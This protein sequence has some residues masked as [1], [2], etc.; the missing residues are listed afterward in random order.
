MSSCQLQSHE[1]S[2]NPLHLKPA[3][4]Q[5]PFSLMAAVRR[6][7][8][9]LEQQRASALA[10]E[11]LNLANAGQIEVSHNATPSIAN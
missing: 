2:L 7:T 1:S 11:A 5:V 10:R 4:K 6:M 3:G 8:Q 9:D